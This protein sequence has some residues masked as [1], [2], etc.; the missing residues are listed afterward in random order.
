MDVAQKSFSLPKSILDKSMVRFRRL[1]NSPA[2]QT[3]VIADPTLRQVLFAKTLSRPLK[4]ISL[5]QH[6]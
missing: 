2:A 4:W 6:P 5:G 3:L 1:Q